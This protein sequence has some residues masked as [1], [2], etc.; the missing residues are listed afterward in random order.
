MLNR[1]IKYKVGFTDWNPWKQPVI[2]FIKPDTNPNVIREDLRKRSFDEYDATLAAEL[3]DG[4]EIKEEAASQRIWGSKIFNSPNPSEMVRRVLRCR[5]PKD[6]GCPGDGNWDFT[7]GLGLPKRIGATFHQNE[8]G[9]ITVT[10]FAMAEAMHL[11]S[12]VL[13][14]D[15]PNCEV[16]DEFKCWSAHDWKIYASVDRLDEHY[17]DLCKNI[18]QAKHEV[19][20]EYSKRHDEGIPQ[21]HELRISLSKEMADYDE[22]ECIDSMKK[23]IHNRD[24]NRK[25]NWKSGGM[26]VR[27]DGAYIRD[28]SNV[29]VSSLTTARV[30]CRDLQ[31]LVSCSLQ[32][33]HHR[34]RGLLDLELWAA[35]DATLYGCVLWIRDWLMGVQVL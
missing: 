6:P 34:R 10:S 11:G 8:N 1:K 27:D 21:E 23:L 22:S 24:T 35:D 30:W 5:D 16:K 15:A 2:H 7:L 4:F 3:E 20:W 14:V 9:H 31:G 29:N 25:M 13:G 32:I 19:R 33:V 17:E 26:Y 12:L 18:E 28:Q